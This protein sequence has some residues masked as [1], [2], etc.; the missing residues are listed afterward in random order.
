MQL[1]LRYQPLD[2]CQNMQCR[3]RSK[4]SERTNRQRYSDIC[5][6]HAFFRNGI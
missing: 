3:S 1:I 5:D 2:N 4:R 6:V